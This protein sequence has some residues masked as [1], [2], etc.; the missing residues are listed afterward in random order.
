VDLFGL[1][2]VLWEGFQA[3]GGALVGIVRA[4]LGLLGLEV[5]DFVVEL[6]TI[7]TLLIV[8]FKFGKFIGTILLVIL[9]LMLASTFLQL[10]IS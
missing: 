2:Q 3:V 4:L 8:V 5:P 6:A 9:L 1:V 10:F 7:I